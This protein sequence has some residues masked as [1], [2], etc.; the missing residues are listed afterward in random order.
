M[1]VHSYSDQ[2]YFMKFQNIVLIK[3]I[4]PSKA[5]TI[6]DNVKK[7]NAD[8]FYVHTLTA[9]KELYSF[10]LVGRVNYYDP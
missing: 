8:M 4:P 9:G 2:Y 10:E 5:Q 7:Q 3:W 1:K 6:I